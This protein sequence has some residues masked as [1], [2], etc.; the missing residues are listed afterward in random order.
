MKSIFDKLNLRPQE[1]RLVVGVGIVVF[2][3]V[4]F[5]FIIPHFGDLGRMQ[6]KKDYAEKELAKFKTELGK[7]AEYERELKRLESVGAY[8]PSEEQA[9]ELQREVYQQ[10]QQTGVII[11]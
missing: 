6:N 11:V 1:R 2:A 4:N 3:V 10:A 7:K 5:W 8:L 9:L